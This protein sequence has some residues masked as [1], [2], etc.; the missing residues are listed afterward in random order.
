[1]KLKNKTIIYILIAII[2]LLLLI[3]LLFD[4]KNT[5]V[6][7][8]LQHIYNRLQKIKKQYPKIINPNKKIIL[9]GEIKYIEDVFVPEY[10]KMISDQ[11]ED[12]SM[13]NSKNL[14]VRKASGMNF[15]DMHKTDNYTGCLET[16]YNSEFL[17]YLSSL[18]KKPLQ[19][20]NS[21]DI[22]S[23][24][25]L[26][27]SQEGDHIYWHIDNS[28]YYG[29]R[30]VVLYTAVNENATKDGVSKNEFYYKLNGKEQ[31]LQLKPNSIIVFKG[32]EIFHKST[33]IGKNE[34][35]VLLSMT[36][37]DICQEKKNIINYIHDKIKNAVTYG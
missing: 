36:F 12:L 8:H 7:K 30:Y 15:I 13:Y 1:M 37:C 6:Q 22:N 31:K 27:Y 33:E 5:D 17:E 2:V 10:H 26:V 35:R 28:I 16:Y 32:S 23:C 3:F 20:T 11:F 4:K 19:R 25:L 21:S 9:D 34:K 14:G 18:I 29:D 24:S